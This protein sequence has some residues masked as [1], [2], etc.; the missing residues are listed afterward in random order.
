MTTL[1]HKI[2]TIGPLTLD[3]ASCKVSNGDRSARLT[4]RPASVLAVLMIAYRENR[5]A[6]H[7]EMQQVV[8]GG[9]AVSDFGNVLRQ[10]IT[11]V[12]RR[13]EEVGF[14]ASK[15]IVNHHGVAY[16]LHHPVRRDTAARSSANQHAQ[17]SA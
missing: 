9:H 10:H 1:S 4:L 11:T 2:R 8:W 16:Q 14:D 15:M 7:Q 12:R 3:M 5:P 17:V 13:L 6:S